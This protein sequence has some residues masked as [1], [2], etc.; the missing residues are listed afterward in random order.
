MPR[1]KNKR[2]WGKNKRSAYR[3]RRNYRRKPRVTNVNRSL[4]PF[5]SR[6]IAKLKYSEAFT[7]DNAN[8]YVQ[9]M[10]LNSLFDPN[11]TGIGHQG[12]GFDQLA[13]IYNRYRVISCRYVIN[14]YSGTSP[15]RFGCLPC[16]EIPPFTS[17]M[18][19]LC[20]N[21]RA[22]WKVQMPNGSTSTI[23]GSVYIP[24]LMGRTK[25]QYMGDDRFQA[26]VT[27]SPQ[28][29]ALL[30]ITGQTLADV[31]T[32]IT[33]TVTLEYTAEFFDPNPLDQS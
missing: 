22:K 23:I 31:N 30:H 28:D 7:L 24:S 32:S 9:V 8:N 15:I 27:G 14:A 33:L 19:E 20:E 5:A 6:Y 25:T 29:L 12:Y 16:N 1:D 21:P 3:P 10:N 18:S 26:Q 13:T 11:R 17:S 2:V 4:Q